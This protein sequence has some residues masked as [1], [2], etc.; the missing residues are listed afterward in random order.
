[1]D[2]QPYADRQAALPRGALPR[3]RVPTPAP[4]SA[5][6]LIVGRVAQAD[7]RPVSYAAVT[8]TDVSGRQVDRAWADGN[9]SYQLVP[10]AAG[11]YILVC[12]AG[13][14]SPTVTLITVGGDTVR[15][16]ILLTGAGTLAGCVRAGE[17]ALP[18]AL[19]TLID[20]AGNVAATAVTDP[21]GRYTVGGLPE[22]TYTLAAVAEHHRPT[23]FAIT[24][25]AGGR[26]E[27]DIELI[28][29]VRLAGTVR[30]ASGKPIEEA[31]VT[32]LDATGTVVN[33]TITGEAGD[34][35]FEEL[36]E[37]TY[38]LTATGYP[39]VA[40]L[41]ELCADMASDV[42]LTLYRARREGRDGRAL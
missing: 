7:G 28:A 25:P 14:N 19:I 6:A 11:T 8:L 37:G 4:V 2:Q 10:P 34:Y 5:S 12:S 22:G 38:T 36:P 20:V 24:I 21:E 9:G 31:L 1:V 27:R 32:V 35:V 29:R 16:D 40:T 39:P 26:T 42:D 41:V 17:E 33:A 15:H 13:A 23:A 30:S 18:G 3:M